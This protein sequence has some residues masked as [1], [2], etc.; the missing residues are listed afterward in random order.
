MGVQL[1][2]IWREKLAEGD[3]EKGYLGKS[4][5]DKPLHT[6]IAD[7]HGECTL[8]ANMVYKQNKSLVEKLDNYELTMI[9]RSGIAQTEMKEDLKN[10]IRYRDCG[11][12]YRL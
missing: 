5:Q 1:D 4:I 8:M 3:I 7:F 9:A 2:G 6:F 11:R 12:F 10:G